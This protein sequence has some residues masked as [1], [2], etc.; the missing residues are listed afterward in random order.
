VLAL[1][2]R[3]ANAAALHSECSLATTASEIIYGHKYYKM[4]AST[5][6]ILIVCRRSALTIAH[7]AAIQANQA[8]EED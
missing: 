4:A 7:Q 3:A 5:R 8:D 2:E 1:L 6:G